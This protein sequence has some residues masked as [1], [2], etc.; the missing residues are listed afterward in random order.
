MSRSG[1][2]TRRVG[3]FVRRATRAVAERRECCRTQRHRTNPATHVRAYRI[4]AAG[5]RSRSRIT[6]R[7]RNREC[8]RCCPSERHVARCVF[9]RP[10]DGRRECLRMSIE[11]RDVE[12]RG[13]IAPDATIIHRDGGDKRDVRVRHSEMSRCAKA[14]RCS[15]SRV[16]S[17]TRG[18]PSKR[19][20]ASM[21]YFSCCVCCLVSC[22]D[23][24]DGSSPRQC[25]IHG[26]ARRGDVEEGTEVTS[27]I[28][29][30]VCRLVSL[31]VFAL[32]VATASFPYFRNFRY[33][34]VEYTR[35][36]M[37]A[38]ASRDVTRSFHVRSRRAIRRGASRYLSVRWYSIYPE[39]NLGA[40]L[41]R[42]IT[43]REEKNSDRRWR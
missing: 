10:S 25:S 4:S 22:A 24:T 21:A 19:R 8:R 31:K 14:S 9:I 15:Q 3:S 43:P 37:F 12:R 13:N 41:R 1:G 32:A 2:K 39:P 27:P 23:S 35:F 17:V 18:V 36:V 33:A 38:V 6:T 5:T 29:R 16:S 28:H 34:K 7:E 20:F 40:R 30:N 11:S 26:R 42:K